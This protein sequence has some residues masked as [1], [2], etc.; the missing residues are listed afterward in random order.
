MWKEWMSTVWPERCWW[1]ESMKDWYYICNWMSFSRPFFAWHCVL[2]DCSPVLWWLSPGEGR[3]ELHDAVGINYK[4]G[5]ATENQIYGHLFLSWES[6]S[7]CVSVCLFVCSDLTWLLF[8][9]GGRKSWYINNIIIYY[10]VCHLQEMLIR[11]NINCI[12][13]SLL[14]LYKTM[15][16]LH[17]IQEMVDDF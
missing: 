2:S 7:A 14:Q 1:P 15:L 17:L 16:I 10:I 8:L 9:G 3:P 13:Y 5:A 6:L 12:L 11:I 4:K